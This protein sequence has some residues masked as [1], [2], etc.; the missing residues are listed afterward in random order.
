MNARGAFARI[1]SGG[2]SAIELDRAALLI[3]AE[4]YPDLM[5]DDYLGK[6][7]DLAERVRQRLYADAGPHE[8][9][10]RLNQVLFDEEGFRGDDKEYFDPRDSYLNAVI[11]R[12]IGSPITLSAGYGEVARRLGFELQGIGF[13]GHF[14]LKHE[15]GEGE[16]LIDAF[17]GGQI[18][19]HD[20]CRERLKR[21]FKDKLEFHPEQLESTTPR[22]MLFR[23]LN[24]LKGIYA[25]RREHARALAAV[26]RMLL[27][28]PD[29][30][31][32][33]RDRGILLSDVGRP[34]EGVGELARYLKLKPDA[35]DRVRI[36]GIIDRLRLQIGM[37]N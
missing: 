19:T 8:T 29:S 33:V 9:L 11:D 15:T 28:V 31:S 26:E 32:E 17:Y 10:A 22:F 18:L 12:R 34:L 36:E 3:A 6:L 4:E 7:D 5:V 25:N 23:I 30:P 24:N 16:I 21:N 37:A 27:L 2:D 13:P 14:L 20:D 35:R 1:V